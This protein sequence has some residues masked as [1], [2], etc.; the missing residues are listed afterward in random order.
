[1]EQAEAR[2]AEMLPGKEKGTWRLKSPS[3]LGVSMGETSGLHLQQQRLSAGV[4]EKSKLLKGKRIR[5][6]NG[7]DLNIFPALTVPLSVPCRE[8]DPIL[9]GS[10]YLGK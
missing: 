7:L 6:L 10:T 4:Q 5:I 8:R 1:M 9:W 3:N 2:S